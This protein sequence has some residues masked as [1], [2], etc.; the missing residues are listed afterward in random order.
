HSGFFARYDANGN[1]HL[2]GVIPSS[3]QGALP[4]RVMG[5]QPDNTA[6]LA[7]AQGTFDVGAGTMGTPGKDQLYLIRFDPDGHLLSSSQ[8]ILEGPSGF[9]SFAAGFD[10]ADDLWLCADTSVPLTLGGAPVTST[11]QGDLLLLHLNLAGNVLEKRQFGA[12]GKLH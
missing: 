5:E 11:S 10:P 1:V 12:T 3:L 9:P 4:I 7:W 8:P 2:S 6:I